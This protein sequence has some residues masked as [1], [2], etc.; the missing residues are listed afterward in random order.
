[1]PVCFGTGEHKG[2]ILRVVCVAEKKGRLMG[3]GWRL[4]EEPGWGHGGGRE[5]ERIWHGCIPGLGN[6]QVR[7]R[8]GCHYFS[9]RV[10]HQVC[11]SCSWLFRQPLKWRDWGRDGEGHQAGLGRRMHEG[12]W[13][14]CRRQAGWRGGGQPS[15]SLSAAGQLASVHTCT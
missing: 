12:G 15:C 2:F 8:E 6:L 1:M 9:G 11:Y 10:Q 14:A 4:D 7:G 13:T 3:Q 5:G